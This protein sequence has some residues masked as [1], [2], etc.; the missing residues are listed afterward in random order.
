[1]GG[2][3][4]AQSRRDTIFKNRYFNSEDRGGVSRR[5]KKSFLGIT[6]NVR[7]VVSG[8]GVQ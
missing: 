1:M 8:G 7:K 3:N 6:V 5:K 4:L 2:M